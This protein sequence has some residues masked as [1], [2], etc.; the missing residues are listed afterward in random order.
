ME[1]TFW[2]PEQGSLNTLRST[3]CDTNYVDQYD[4]C[5]WFFLMRD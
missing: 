1:G 3:V 5:D 4:F 2:D